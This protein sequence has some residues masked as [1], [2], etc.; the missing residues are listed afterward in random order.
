MVT[1]IVSTFNKSLQLMTCITSLLVQGGDKE[2]IICDNSDNPDSIQGNESVANLAP[3]IIRRVDTR[4]IEP[5]EYACF[6]SANGVYKE[7]KG[8]WLCFPS[9]DSYY[10]PGYSTIM[11]EHAKK[12]NWDLVYCDF[13][14]DPRYNGCYYQ[15][16]QA[17][18][19]ARCIDKTVF[20][21]KKEVFKGW[22]LEDT[23]WCDWLT[24]KRLIENGAKHGHVPGVMVV[25]N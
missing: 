8:D 23:T 4:E 10:V 1:Y 11:L 20:M 16:V 9:D 24:F 13:L 5:K 22:A 19:I 21:V 14:Y 12:F 17:A 15:V 18:P 25:H 7:A 2:I 6:A 3:H